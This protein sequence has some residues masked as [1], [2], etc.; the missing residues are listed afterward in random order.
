MPYGSTAQALGQWIATTWDWRLFFTLTLT[1]MPRSETFGGR[2]YYGVSHTERLLQLWAEG[3]IESRGGY[4]WA[5]L[6]SHRARPTPHVH[7]IAGGFDEDPRRI[8]MWNE[9]RSIGSGAGRAEVLPVKSAAGCAIYV[10]KYVNKGLGKIYTGGSLE[11]R[12]G[13]AFAL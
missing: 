2:T 13:G 12:K 1:D 4:W 11:L 5:A 6:E 10:A 8:A 7:G 9:W 3:A